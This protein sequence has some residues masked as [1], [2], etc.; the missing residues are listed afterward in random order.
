MSLWDEIRED[1]ADICFGTWYGKLRKPNK[2]RKDGTLGG[3][4]KVCCWK[5]YQDCPKVDSPKVACNA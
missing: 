3:T 2:T 4:G 1:E 5:S